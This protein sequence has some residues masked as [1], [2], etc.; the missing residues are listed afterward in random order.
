ME[1]QLDIR[2]YIAVILKWWWLM[3][4]C[5]LVAGTSSYLATLQMPRIYR[6]TTTVMIGRSLEKANPDIQDVAMSQQLAM[7]YAEMVKRRPILS[8]AA[9]ALGLSF[10]PSSGSISTEQIKG[11]QLLEISVRDTDPARAAALADEIASQMILQSP[12]GNSEEEQRRAFIRQQLEELQA[13]IESSKERIE[14]EQAK[15]ETANSAR[16]I[17]QYQ[18]N[19]SALEGKVAS[20]QSTYAALLYG[21]QGGSNYISIIEPATQPTAPISPDVQQMVLVAAAIGLALAVGGAFLMEYLDDTIRSPEDA[22]SATGLPLMAEIS[23]IDGTD[24]PSQLVTMLSPLSPISEAFRGLRT[25]VRFAS[26][27]SPLRTLMV[28]SAGPAEGKSVTLANLGVVFAQSGIKVLV[29]D[30]DLRRPVQHTIFGLPNTHGLSDLFLDEDPNVSDYIQSTA[31]ENLFLISAGQPPPNPSELLASE[32]LGHLITELLQE[33]DLVLFD[34][35]PSMVVT[36]AAVL[37]SRVDGVLMV[38][39][40]TRTYRKLAAKGA[41][42]LRRSKSSLLGVVLNRVPPTRAGYYYHYGYYYY[43][44]SDDETKDKGRHRRHASRRRKWSWPSWLR[45]G[46]G[47]SD[48]AEAPPAAPMEQV[49]DQTAG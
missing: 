15:L 23:R 5:A 38:A 43:G 31:A 32:R 37:G 21:A 9:K 6:A 7:T 12:A 28:T 8:G 26:V 16:A 20:H 41:H 34:S 13:R 3:L 42:E 29:A 25:N 14:T 45:R 27:D 36:D 49:P 46:R 39:D 2:Q 10:V 40:H 11:T 17:Q 33:M 44:R 35:P 1:N 24:Y 22:M 18:T 30:T 19:I 47:Q 4:V 48:P